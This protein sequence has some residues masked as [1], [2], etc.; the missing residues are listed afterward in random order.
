MIKRFK[1]YI[2]EK[3]NKKVNVFVGDLKLITE[4]H[5]DFF[6]KIYENTGCK[7]FMVHRQPKYYNPLN[8]DFPKTLDAIKTNND[9][10]IDYVFDNGSI[11][12]SNILGILKDKNFEV[13]KWLC[14]DG[15]Q[16]EFDDVEVA[17]FDIAY[18][19]DLISKIVSN[20]SVKNEIPNYILESINYPILESKTGYSIFPV[21]TKEIADT[22]IKELYKIIRDYY[23]KGKIAWDAPISLNSKFPKKLKIRRALNNPHF[24]S[25]MDKNGIKLDKATNNRFKGIIID[26]GDGSRGGNGIFSKGFSFESNLENDLK[27]FVAEGLTSSEFF[28][29]D[30]VIDLVKRFELEKATKIEVTDTSVN[31]TYRPLK[32]VGGMILIDDTNS[33]SKIADLT[34]NV[35]EGERYL[36]L[37]YAAGTVAFFNIGVAKILSPKEIANGLITNAQGKA[38]LE[39]FNLD[40]ET[41]CSVFNNYGDV[42]FKDKHIRFKP[43]NEISTFLK[44][45]F[46]NGYTMI[47]LLKKGF[48]VSEVNDDFLR[49]NSNIVSD[50]LIR[51]GG[52]SGDGKRIDIM[53]ST[54]EY[55]FLLA[56]RNKQG[57]LYPSHIICNYSHK[58]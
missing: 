25:Y 13:Y 43:T 2:L 52:S 22:D 44:S 39:T 29:K 55:D 37:K 18:I 1:E 34:L 6:N 14:L 56:I 46:G 50:V 49:K 16:L 31:D 27:R 51:Y 8:F 40:N 12:L 28:Y 48:A 19:E 53:F 41:F 7:I 42:N 23:K 57:G 11:K 58:K 54:E 9:S 32:L 47:N 5:I 21:H 38:L 17:D 36:S 33:A 3:E 15:E 26:W 35:N 20:E 30:L 4:K 24:K 10:V 45:G